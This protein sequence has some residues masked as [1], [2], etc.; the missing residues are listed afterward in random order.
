MAWERSADVP[1]LTQA[2]LHNALQRGNAPER[3]G[4]WLDLQPDY[5]HVA[6]AGR[7][8]TWTTS[9]IASM[10]RRPLLSALDGQ[11]RAA[12]AAGYADEGFRPGA[13]RSCVC[14]LGGL[15]HLHHHHLHRPRTLQIAWAGA[16][17]DGP[18]TRPTSTCSSRRPAPP[19]VRFQQSTSALVTSGRRGAVCTGGLKAASAHAGIGDLTAPAP[20]TAMD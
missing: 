17:L 7:C 1:R 3:M 15:Q 18:V 20:A 10:Q 12:A 16:M 13:G 5:R 6:H 19:M 8:T 2:G 9:S 4:A 14:P 11:E